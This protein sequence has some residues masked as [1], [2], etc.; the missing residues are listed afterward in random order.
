VGVPQVVEVQAAVVLPQPR[1]L[2]VLERAVPDTPEVVTCKGTAGALRAAWCGEHEV[3]FLAAN[4][5]PMGR[6]GL[7]GLLVQRDGAPASF[8]LGAFHQAATRVGRVAERPHDPQPR[9]PRDGA[10]VERPG[11]LQVV[12]AQG[13]QLTPAQAGERGS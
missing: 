3:P 7:D 10:V 1:E 9:W 2:G 12:P 5:L 8:C 11:E 13:G 4:Q 6:Q